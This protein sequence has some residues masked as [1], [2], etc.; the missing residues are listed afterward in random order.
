[1]LSGK[2]SP[3]DST[4]ALVRRALDA[5]EE[6]TSEDRLVELLRQMQQPETE[7]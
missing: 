5:F 4:P 6:E 7:S 3:H 1:M 2:T